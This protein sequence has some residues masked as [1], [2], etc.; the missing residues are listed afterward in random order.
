MKGECLV[1]KKI[2]VFGS[3]VVDLM[4]RAPRLPVVGETVIGSAFK[5]GPGGKGFNQ[6][7]A[8]HKAGAD[9]IMV[10]KLGTDLFSKVALDSMATLG[11]DTTYI[12]RTDKAQTGSAL[13]MV[14]EQTGENAI[15]VI[16]GACNTITNEEVDS[17]LEKIEKEKVE[18]FLVQLEINISAVER[19]IKFAYS[20]NIKVIL[21]P[22]P[23]QSISDGILDKVDIVTPNKVEAEI[24]TNVTIESENDAD[25][26][27]DWFF[28]RGVGNVVITLGKDGAYVATKERREVVP[29]FS[30]KEIDTTGAGDA[31]NGGL[32]TALA[33]GKNLWEAVKFANAV[34][35]LSVQKI[36]TTPSM[37]TRNQVD[38]FIKLRDIKK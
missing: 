4:G 26:A 16:L 28:N 7:V 32:A 18:Y 37:P 24:Y 12:F 35:A 20:N 10:T 6:G 27:A 8:A 19:A 13:I 5:M 29:A 21:N 38:E 23:A 33:E 2:V 9:I 34:A 36:G 25:R 15:V 31:F 1:S 22:A 3:F 14:D 11:M 30:V 17:V